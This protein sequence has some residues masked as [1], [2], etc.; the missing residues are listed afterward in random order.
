LRLFS[1]LV[2]C[3]LIF[4]SIVSASS[5]TDSG[6]WS[7]DSAMALLLVS[8]LAVLFLL[9]L[10]ALLI[11]LLR[12][13]LALR[14][15][16]P[17]LLALLPALMMLLRLPLFILWSVRLPLLLT[18]VSSSFLLIIV[19]ILLTTIAASS[20]RAPTLLVVTHFVSLGLLGILLL[21]C[22]ASLISANRAVI[23]VASSSTA[24]FLL[25]SIA[26][27]LLVL[28]SLFDIVC[29]ISCKFF[30][31][32][33]VDLFNAILIVIGSLISNIGRSG[34]FL[35]I[36]LLASFFFE[37][38][39]VLIVRFLCHSPRWFGGINYLSV[40][41]IGHLNWW[42]HCFISIGLISFSGGHFTIFV[43]NFAR[44]R[45]FRLRITRRS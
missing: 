23:K 15:L 31:I 24:R 4:G 37:A 39:L 21:I 26:G 9:P 32:S 16:A 29:G 14:M 19:I 38:R 20:A 43:E 34:R 28:R 22:S 40:R 11:L 33:I 6:L 30:K 41:F 17:F 35:F 36:Q 42:A 7:Q 10:L 44:V 3:C 25:S 5:A 8:L 18:I 45:E 13:V 1:T 27:L 2:G 12:L